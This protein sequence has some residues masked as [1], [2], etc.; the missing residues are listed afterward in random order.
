MEIRFED[1]LEAL[2]YSEAPKKPET[3]LFHH[4]CGELKKQLRAFDLKPN[5]G[6]LVLRDNKLYYITWQYIGIFKRFLRRLLAVTL[7]YRNPIEFSKLKATV[8]AGSMAFI[9]AS[10]QRST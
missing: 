3:A 6:S 1:Y 9:F 4:L 5:D 7:H 10:L 8:A 2:R